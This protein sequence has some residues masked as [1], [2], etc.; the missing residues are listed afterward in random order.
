MDCTQ[1]QEKKDEFLTFLEVERR[2]A[3]NTIRSYA[4][5][6]HQFFTFWSSITT[7]VR[8]ISCKEAIERFLVALFHKKINRNSIARKL[9]CFKSFERFLRKDNILLNLD[10]KRPRAHKKLPLVL[11]V[12]DIVHLLDQVTDHDIKTRAPVRTKLIVELLYATGIR[13]A[14]LV[15]IRL[16]DIDM[17]NKTIRICGKGKRERMVLFGSK[18]HERIVAYLTHERPLAHTMHEPLLLNNRGQALTSRSVQRMFAALRPLLPSKRAITP[19][20]LRHS[21]ATHLLAQGVD[22]RVVQELLGHQTITS[23]QIYTHVSVEHLIKLCDDKHPL[24]NMPLE[25]YE[26]NE[27]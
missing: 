19:H 20:K 8:S 10:L 21:F 17:N 25:R 22:L 15:S 12:D 2:L 14:E 16:I 27:Q 13:C 23:T 5:D 24:L 18:A 26:K 11:S 4:I 3:R 7:P 9:S 6:L 1:F